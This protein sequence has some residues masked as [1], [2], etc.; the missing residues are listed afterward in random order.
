MFILPSAF[1][2]LITNNKVQRMV[3]HLQNTTNTNNSVYTVSLP[4]I[5]N[6]ESMK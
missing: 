6:L 5:N 1:F 3:K 2:S 4:P